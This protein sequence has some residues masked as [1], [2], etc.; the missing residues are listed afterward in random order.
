MVRSCWTVPAYSPKG[1]K[2]QKTPAENA[3]VYAEKIHEAV[4]ERSVHSGLLVDELKALAKEDRA[5]IKRKEREE[6]V[7]KRDAMKARHAQKRAGHKAEA[8][9]TK[10]AAAKMR[11][12]A[13]TK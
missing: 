5:E 10:K 2:M 11:K 8:A 4:G 7:A 6:R 12:K 13:K 3:L 1:L 9:A